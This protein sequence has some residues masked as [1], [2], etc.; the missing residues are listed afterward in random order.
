[1]VNFVPL[2][3]KFIMQKSIRLVSGLYLKLSLLT[4]AVGLVLRV[5]LLFNEQTTS[6]AFSFGEWCEVFLLGAVNDFCAATAGFIFL[7][8]FML[9]VSRTKYRKPWGYI[10]LALL[11][12]AFCYV[13]FFNTIFDEYGSVAPQ[14]A[15][16]VLGYW[17]GSFALRLFLPGFRSHWTTVWFALFI[18]VYVGAIIFN[19]ISEYFFWSEFGVRYNFIAVDYLVYTNEVVGNI[20][21]SYP[22]VPLFAGVLLLTVGCTWLLFRREIR[23][24]GE[25]G[26]WQWKAAVS[27]AYLLL[28]LGCCL[29]LQFNTRFQQSAN[30]YANELQAT[31]AYK[32]YDAFMKNELS[33]PQFYLTLPQK[34]AEANVHAIYGSTG[35]NLRHIPGNPDTLR[36]NIVLITIESMS[37]SFMQHFGYPD[38]IT[39]H[40]DSLYKMGIAFEQ[41]F[42]TGNRTVRGLEA[43]TLSLPPCPGQSIIKRPR[44]DNMHSTAAVLREKGYDAYYFY[45]GNSYFDNM[46][47]F[48][49]GNGYRIIDQ[50]S[51][52]P[53]EITFANIWGVCDEDAYR[54]VIRTLNEDAQSGKPFFAH[55]M[56]VSNHRPYTY[57]AG[58]IPIPNDAKLRSG[59]VMY[60][61]YALGRF[62]EEAS[63]QPW[64]AN[65]VFVITADHC[66]SSAGKTEI[67]LEKYHIPALIFAPG[68]ITPQQVDKVI[69]Q[70]DLM[71][72]LFSLLGM[73][74]DSHFFGQDALSDDFRERAFVA[75]YQDL[76]YLE[77][78]VFTVLSPV[79]RAEQYRI[80]PTEED[81]YNLVLEEGIPSQELLDRAI[82]LYQTSSAW[83]TR[84]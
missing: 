20:M 66:A 72:T 29:L 46:E 50:K 3:P 69:S 28:T 16:Y 35:D 57:P 32:F 6:L 43:V 78:D 31:G 74:Y 47:T 10:L 22:V 40:L 25:F 44:N 34:E 58:R 11:V 38:A 84:P 15:L 37:A 49:G 61:D 75:T 56:T 76:G 55:V 65:T 67:P 52:K 26:T 33:Y 23:R 30:T 79:N 41:C 68:L 17:A 24:A 8:L 54:K 4:V 73:D 70:I 12:A 59:G 83:N 9:S 14:I 5:V 81:R 63:R 60:T 77:G 42:A 53:E 36:R 7:W 80:S 21:E 82:S 13:A 18:V 62:F 19:G 1:M 2:I 39:P 48:F 64:F 71:P 51:Y 45:G 27:P